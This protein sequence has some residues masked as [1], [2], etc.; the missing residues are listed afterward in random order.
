MQA[1]GMGRKVYEAADTWPH[2]LNP[3]LGRG[4]LLYSLQA[5]LELSHIQLVLRVQCEV[6]TCNLGQSG[7]L[8]SYFQ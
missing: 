4:Q 5:W 8:L 3:I 2:T 6:P 1:R 7:H